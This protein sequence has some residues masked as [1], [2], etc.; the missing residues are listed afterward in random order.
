MQVARVMIL[1]L[2]AKGV[3]ETIRLVFER[4]TMYNG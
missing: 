1:P 2:D 3:I 4:G